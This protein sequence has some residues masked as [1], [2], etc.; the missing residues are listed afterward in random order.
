MSK[1]DIEVALETVKDQATLVNDLLAGALQWPLEGKVEK[2]EEIS[3]D[4]TAEDLRA[5]DLKGVTVRQIQ[6]FRHAQPWGI[7]FIEF[8]N[9]RVYKT[10]L[11][12]ILR[13]LVP[14]RR[15]DPSLEAWQHPNLLFICATRNYDSVTFAHF[16][17]EHAQT[18]RLAIFG[19]RKDDPR[20]RTV[21]EFNL[22]A[23][24]W[25]DDDGADGAAWLK[26][27]TKAF[28][29][30]PLTKDFFKRF[31]RALDA[32]QEDLQTHQKFSA[33]EAYSKAQ[34]LLERLVFLYF[35]QNSEPRLAQPGA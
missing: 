34:L 25:P 6:P 21:R 4:W 13:G 26:A 17:G 1:A 32:I 11:R 12:Q 24:V 22:P 8:A 19:W 20:N 27:W 35:L 16:R 14:S 9:E 30:E 10:K 28:D 7:F 33:A 29:K 23:L 15:H 5:Q 3:Y 2:A 31:D 18:A